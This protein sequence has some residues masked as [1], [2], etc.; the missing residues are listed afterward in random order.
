MKCRFTNYMYIIRRFNEER[1]SVNRTSY[2]A[3]MSYIYHLH[4]FVYQH[5]HWDMQYVLYVKLSI[6]ND[7][8]AKYLSDRIYW[9]S[10]HT[11]TFALPNSG[12]NFSSPSTL[13]YILLVNSAPFLALIETQDTRSLVTTD[14]N[15]IYTKIYFKQD[16]IILNFVIN[17]RS[18]NTLF[19]YKAKS[20]WSSISSSNK[21]HL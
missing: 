21:E 13:K 6:I 3:S 17:S 19:V 12:G 5:M 16:Q 7:R 20:Y 10:I 4:I 18:R 2:E 9:K 1:C 15:E 8:V 14:F 11:E